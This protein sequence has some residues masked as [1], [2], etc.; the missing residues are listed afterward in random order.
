MALRIWGVDFK[1]SHWK[2]SKKGVKMH[3]MSHIKVRSS[4]TYYFLLA[5][6]GE[7]C[8]ELDALKIAMGF[9]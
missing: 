4:T 5:E 8:I 1:I 6:F 3:M 9:Q 2:G 7:L